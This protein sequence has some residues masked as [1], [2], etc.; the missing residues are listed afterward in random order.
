[1]RRGGC[2]Q[3]IIDV[4]DGQ[5]GGA[6]IQHREQS[7]KTAKA[8]SI[9]D[10]GRN[11]DDTAIDESSDDARQR[12]FHSRN[13]NYHISIFQIVCML[14]QAMDARDTNVVKRA[15]SVAQ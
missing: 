10:A 12:P 3:A 5:A 6:A 14:E 11:S 4:D 1:M 13:Y 8:G 7:G 9:S 15:R 2:A